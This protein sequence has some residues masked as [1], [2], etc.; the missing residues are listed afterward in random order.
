MTKLNGQVD[1]I[2]REIYG[3]GETRKETNSEKLVDLQRIDE[4][5][6]EIFTLFGNEM[7]EVML[8]HFKRSE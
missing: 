4:L 6:N 1:K 8:N 7:E 2:L 5:R 3:L